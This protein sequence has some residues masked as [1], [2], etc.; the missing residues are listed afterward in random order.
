[1]TSG[2]EYKLLVII[3]SDPDADGLVRALVNAG[4]SATKIGS[5]GGFLRRGNT[6]LLCGV[7][8]DEV[9]TV[10]AMVRRLCPP[11]TELLSVSTLPVA[12]EMPYFTEP[13]EVRAGGAVLF[14][15]SVDRFERI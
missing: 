12:G 7:P 2:P 13:I 1:M 15:L 11:R 4:H 3:A 8:G 5:T 14:V 10:I 9:E 6:T